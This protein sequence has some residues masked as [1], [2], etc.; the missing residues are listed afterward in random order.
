MI[1]A[2]DIAL[3]LCNFEVV[4]KRPGIFQVLGP[5][6]HEDGD[7]VDVFVEHT[8]T[9]FRISDYGM[10][11]MRLSYSTDKL[12]K[13]K[14]AIVREIAQASGAAIE[15]GEV[16]V[17]A[18]ENDLDAAVFR[19]VATVTRISAATY[20][21][22]QSPQKMFFEELSTFVHAKL[23]RFHPQEDVYPIPHR[24]EY[25][26][27]YRFNHR[28]RPVYLFGIA[29]KSKAR[30]TTISVQFFKQQDLRFR[31]LAVLADE[32]A[33]T[34][35]DKTRLTDAVDTVYPSLFAFQTRAMDVLLI[36]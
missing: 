9:G 18:A 24:D 8:R 10:T 16:V 23:E 12:S 28:E 35:K 27:D 29:G 20:F 25:K 22:R 11:I 34:G 15:N 30:L 4:E 33:V 26:V 7:M 14:R 5:F 13:A 32:D 21:N 17:R 2:K 3:R 36:P 6:Y 19:F 31:S 1:Q